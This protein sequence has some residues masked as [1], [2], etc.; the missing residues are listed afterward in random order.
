[1]V[2]WGLGLDDDGNGQSNEASKSPQESRRLSIQRCIQSLVH[3]CQCR[4]A[5]CSSSKHEFQAETKKLL[6]IVARS[7]YSEKEVFIRELISNGSD[8]LEKLRHKLMTAGGETAPMEIHLKTD[9]N[10]GTFTIQDTGVGM[11]Q[12]ELVENLGTIARSGSKVFNM[13][14]IF[15]FM[16]KETVSQ[17]YN[18]HYSL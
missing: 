4:N 16:S 18:K 5:N 10:Q 3:A 11:N 8:A 15:Q 17:F 9:A 13:Q 2:K 14:Y 1:M 6:D 7:L 12:T